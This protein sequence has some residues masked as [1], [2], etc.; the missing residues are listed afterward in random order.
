MTT[1]ACLVKTLAVHM[2]V[3]DLDT[4]IELMTNF[5]YLEKIY[6]RNEVTILH[7]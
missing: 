6:I 7:L 5:P 2:P 3:L 1:V 4:V